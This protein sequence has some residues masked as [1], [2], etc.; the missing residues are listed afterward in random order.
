MTTAATTEHGCCEW[1]TTVLCNA[2]ATGWK[3]WP[4]ISFTD[5]GTLALSIDDADDRTTPKSLLQ[6]LTSDD[7]P[8][9]RFAAC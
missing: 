7:Q 1:D 8:P 2:G 4:T 3:L 9:I 5:S 6:G